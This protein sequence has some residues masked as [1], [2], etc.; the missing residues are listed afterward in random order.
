VLIERAP[1]EWV[2]KLL[3]P[4]L[5]CQIPSHLEPLPAELSSRLELFSA[6]LDDESQSGDCTI[7]IQ[8]PDEI[9]VPDSRFTLRELNSLTR[10]LQYVN[11]RGVHVITRRLLKEFA[12]RNKAAEKALDSW[13][14]VAKKAHWE[15][16]ADVRMI[17]PHAD[18]V[19]KCTVFNIGG[20]KYR[21]IVKI[22]YRLET[23]YI[24]RVLTHAE[25]DKGDWKHDC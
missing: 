7:S 2:D 19:R 25:Y 24:K 14:G 4:A 22:E 10:G 16:I 5:S 3:I 12:A 9:E 6:L 1:Q 17:Y 21:L 23:I 11:M 20:N 15:S 8:Q 13:Y 18:S